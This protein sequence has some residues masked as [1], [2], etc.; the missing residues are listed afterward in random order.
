MFLIFQE[1]V[2]CH[3]FLDE[4]FKWCNS[5]T[6][7]ASFLPAIRHLFLATKVT[8]PL[9]QWNLLS[10][11]AERVPFVVLVVFLFKIGRDFHMG[12]L[13]TDG[14]VIWYYR[15]LWCYCHVNIHLLRFMIG[16]TLLLMS[17]TCHVRANP[18]SI[19]FC[20]VS[21]HIIF[22]KCLCSSSYYCDVNTGIVVSLF[23]YFVIY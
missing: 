4:C 8:L 3:V 18:F 2:A 22:A 15:E 5:E 23:I 19:I 7:C 6:I 13:V 17:L 1:W 16:F 9:P 20:C 14:H 21:V 10:F 11:V 12:I